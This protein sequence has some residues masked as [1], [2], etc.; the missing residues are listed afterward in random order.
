M[1]KKGI[2]VI[3]LLINIQPDIGSL[4]IKVTE[5]LHF[6]MDTDVVLV[7]SLILST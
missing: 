2:A 6:Y 3:H 7:E 1:N 4:F 5:I